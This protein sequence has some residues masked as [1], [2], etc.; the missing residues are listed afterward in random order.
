VPLDD[1]LPKIA[2]GDESLDKGLS[3]VETAMTKLV[4]G[5]GK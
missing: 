1:E 2:G 4:P 3:N 5:F